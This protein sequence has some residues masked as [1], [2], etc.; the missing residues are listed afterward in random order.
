MTTYRYLTFKLSSDLFR[1]CINL[2]Y[3][4][5]DDRDLKDAITACA[6]KSPNG[7]PNNMFKVEPDTC[8]KYRLTTIA[9]SVPNTIKEINKFQCETARI[10]I[11]K[12]QPSRSGGEAAVSAG[13]RACSS[14]SC[15]ASSA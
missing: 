9:G 15:P 11:L 3:Y 4:N 1:E 5:Y 2:V 6:I 13:S 14:C 8:D 10:R 12:Q 7:M